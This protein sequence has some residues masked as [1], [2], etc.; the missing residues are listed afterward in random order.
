MSDE[1]TIHLVKWLC[2][3]YGE[4]DAS[5][6]AYDRISTFVREY[7]DT[8]NTRSWSEIDRMAAR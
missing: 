1:T 2:A 6:A 3:Q 7:P 8:L 4:G 5:F